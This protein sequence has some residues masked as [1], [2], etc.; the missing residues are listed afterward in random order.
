MSGMVVAGDRLY[1]GLCVECSPAPWW[2]DYEDF[3]IDLRTNHATRVD[4]ESDGPRPNSRENPELD[5]PAA[6]AFAEPTGVTER[7]PGTV[8][9]ARADDLAGRGNTGN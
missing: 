3:E 1:A 4:S 2:A 5:D 8:A 9:P 7:A 6:E